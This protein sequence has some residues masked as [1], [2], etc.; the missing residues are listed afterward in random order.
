MDEDLEQLK[1]SF[2]KLQEGLTLFEGF[3]DTVKQSVG[4]VKVKVGALVD[5]MQQAEGKPKHRRRF[6]RI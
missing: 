2:I 5:G 1:E 6:W 4:D 3:L